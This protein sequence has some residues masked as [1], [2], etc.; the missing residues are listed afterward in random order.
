MPLLSVIV[1]I[2]DG[3]AHLDRCL[4]ALANQREAPPLEV[5]VPVY[6][7]IE[8][9]PALRSCWPQVR[10]VEVEGIPP[11]RRS[12]AHW[13][14]DRR[15]A[16]GL[17]AAAGELVAITEDHAIPERDWCAKIV[18]L[19]RAPHAAIGGAIEHGGAGGL[20]WAVELCDFGRYQK[21]FAAGAAEYV[22]DI[23]VSYKRAALM[24]CVHLWRDFYHETAVHGWMRANAENLWLTP[25]LTVWHD[26]GRLKFASLIPER[27]YWGRVFAGRRAQKMRLFRRLLY[28]ALSPALPFLLLTRAFGAIRRTGGPLRRFFA[29]T[30]QV[31]VLL[32][33]WAAGEF[34]GY[35]TAK[36][37]PA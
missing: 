28:A 17:L 8:D 27:F 19:H 13:L 1:T 15:R 32:C 12:M 4:A 20:N 14:Y 11:R 23:N 37:F 3:E 5:I 30:P 29:L 16:A 33:A 31:L 35:A 2:T 25:K 34:T 7:S 22:S 36:P 26:R 18:E 24:R 21:P 10:F 9:V 6:H